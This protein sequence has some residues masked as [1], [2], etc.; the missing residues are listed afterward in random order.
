MNSSLPFHLGIIPTDSQPGV[1]GTTFSGT[2]AQGVGAWCGFWTPCSSEGTAP[3]EISLPI[4]SHTALF[5]LTIFA[6]IGK[7]IT[8]ANI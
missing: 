7:Y 3:T 6:V 2:G 1:M 8:F 4:F 5:P